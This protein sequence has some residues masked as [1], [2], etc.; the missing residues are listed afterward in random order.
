MNRLVLNK[1]GKTATVRWPGDVLSLAF[2][3]R[4]LDAMVTAG[5]PS[6]EV[7]ILVGSDFDGRIAKDDAGCHLLKVEVPSNYP[8]QMSRGWT[9]MQFEDAEGAVAFCILHEL[10]HALFDKEDENA[11]D[12][13]ALAVQR[14][15]DLKPPAAVQKLAVA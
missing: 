4:L 10:G 9:E 3:E 6:A 11:A 2:V 1:D 8:V 14:D 7:Y 12:V 13:W 15:F 5:P